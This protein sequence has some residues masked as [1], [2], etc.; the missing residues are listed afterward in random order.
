LTA[1]PPISEPGTPSPW[2]EVAR[3][4]RRVT[5]LRSSG[6]SPEAEFIVEKELPAALDAARMSEPS[7]EAAD[8]RIAAVYMLEEERMAQAAATAEL[9][10][11]MLVDR[12]RG[13]WPLAA[14]GLSLQSDRSISDRTEGHTRPLSTP[15]STADLIDG[16]LA[17][18]SAER[19][20]RR[21]QRSA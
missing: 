20:N 18:E 14:T 10:A 21:T 12:L 8:R 1:F 11:P 4:F 9:L 6:R 13:Q 17:L 5:L 2:G 16:M 3:I 19:G 7:Q 15:L